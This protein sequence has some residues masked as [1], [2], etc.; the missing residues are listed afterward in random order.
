MKIVVPT[1][2][3][4]VTLRQFIEIS[5]VPELGFS[6]EDASLRVLSILTGVDDTDLMNLDI[7]YLKKITLTASFVG[8]EVPKYKL[9]VSIKIKGNRYE[10]NYSTNKLIAGE[11]ID[12]QDYIKKGANENLN[13]I[14]AIYL[15][16]VNFFRFRKRNCYKKNPNGEYIQTLES[17]NKTA[18]LILDLTMDKIFPM[19]A[20]FLKNWENLIN[21]TKV[22]LA[23]Q[24]KIAMKNLKAKL[25]KADLLKYMGGI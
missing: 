22:Y 3:S 13:N 7:S 15:K 16:P 8:K 10:V 25:S 21:H 11:Y 12:L 20:F 24:N 19:S 18:E 14:I 23:K 4:E 17:R 2:W 1:S 6:D 5:K 9:P